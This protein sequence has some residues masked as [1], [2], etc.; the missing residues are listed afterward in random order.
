MAGEFKPDAVIA[1][2][3]NHDYVAAPGI[4]DKRMQPLEMGNGFTMAVGSIASAQ[5]NRILETTAREQGIPMQR[6]IVGHDTGTDGMAG[7]SGI[8]GLCGHLDRLSH[9]QHAHH[10]RDRSYP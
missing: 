8:R 9:S 6:D 7:R 10:L 5:L 2:D 4:G 1:V 3:V